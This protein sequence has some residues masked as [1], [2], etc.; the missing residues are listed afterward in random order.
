MRGAEGGEASSS[1]LRKWCVWIAMAVARSHNEYAGLEKID[2]GI[3][4][5]YFG[6]LKLG[7]LHERH[8]RI[9]DANGSLIRHR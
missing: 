4:N 9:E 2:G 1:A 5:G 7:R 3:W 8:M 6:S